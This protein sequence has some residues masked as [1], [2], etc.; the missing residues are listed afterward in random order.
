MLLQ[1]GIVV[2][3]KTRCA[4]VAL[5]AVV[6]CYADLGRVQPRVHAANPLRG[7]DEHAIYAAEKAQA[8]IYG[9]V[10]GG[11]IRFFMRKHDGAGAAATLSTGD[12]CSRQ[13][14]VAQVVC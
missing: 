14:D 2:R 5:A 7:C 6:F 12:L 3:D 13:T 10:L 9:Y 11:A 4:K 1:E 8:G